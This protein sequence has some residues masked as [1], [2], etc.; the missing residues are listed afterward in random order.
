MRRKPQ[1]PVISSKSF[2]SKH[3]NDKCIITPKFLHTIISHDGKNVYTTK[4]KIITVIHGYFVPGVHLKKILLS[5][6]SVT[7]YPD[8]H[9]CFRFT[10]KCIN[11]IHQIQ[12]LSWVQEISSK[13]L[14]RSANLSRNWELNTIQL[15]RDRT[16]GI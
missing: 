12:T 7:K 14:F 9:G 3:L 1:D 5:C 8:C 15:A 2:G 13:V 6:L 10:D 16:P 4:V 11:D